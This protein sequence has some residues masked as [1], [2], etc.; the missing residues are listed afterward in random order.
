MSCV[1]LG[2]QSNYLINVGV[3]DK[4]RATSL[5]LIFDP[6]SINFFPFEKIHD[7]DK[8][9]FAGC[10]SGRLVIEIAK[11][12]RRRNLDVKIV[13][14]DISEQQLACARDYAEQENEYNIDWRLQDVH[15]LEDLKGQFNVVH[16]RFLLNH[17]SDAGSVTEL[18][19]NTLR[20]NG[21]FIGE[22][23]AGDEVDVYPNL[24]EYTDA[25]GE[26]LKGVRLNQSIQQSD[27]AFAKYLPGILENNNM[28]VTRELQPN[29]TAS[30]EMQKNVFPECMASAHRIFPTELHH[31]IPVITAALVNVRDAKECSINFKYFTQI[32]AIKIT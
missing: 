5:N 22:E 30:N 32:E 25:I 20:D 23:F 1:Q 11:E 3:A 8:I 18:L 29:P 31:M 13:A 21:I 12:I 2:H 24:P 16:S 7:D 17:L 6:Y 28:I 19:C 10:G 15:N 4:A 27:M 9:L 26:W 14:F